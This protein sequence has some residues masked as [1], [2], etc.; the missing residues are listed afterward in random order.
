MVQQG[1]DERK[2]LGW[3]TELEY[4]SFRCFEVVHVASLDQ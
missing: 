3:Q 1:S 4:H 2:K